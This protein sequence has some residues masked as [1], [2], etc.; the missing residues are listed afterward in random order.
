MATSLFLSGWY[1][2]LPTYPPVNF[3]DSVN[4]PVKF[5]EKIGLKTRI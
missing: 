1:E 3:V 2:K 4:S 5:T